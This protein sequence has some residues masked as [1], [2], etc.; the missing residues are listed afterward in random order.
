MNRERAVVNLRR[1]EHARRSQ[2]SVQILRYSHRDSN[3][4]LLDIVLERK[5]RVRGRRFVYFERLCHNLCTD[6]D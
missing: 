3:G 4:G 5:E 6:V 2:G 1:P